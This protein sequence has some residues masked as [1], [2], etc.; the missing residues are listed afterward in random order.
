MKKTDPLRHSQRGSAL[1][2]VMMLSMGLM[3]VVATT[4]S[5]SLSESRMNYREAMRIEARNAA[6]AISEFGL[7][8]IRYKMD[9]RSDFTP[10][11][12]TTGTD[13]N[14]ISLPSTTY[15]GGSNVVASTSTGTS[16]EL[17]IGLM[18]PVTQ[19][20]ATG[21]YYYDEKDIANENDVLKGRYVFRFD[22]K[23]ISKATVNAP[24]RI[25][26]PAH[27]AYI[28]QTLSARASPLFSHAIFYNM[29]L[30]LWPGPTM[31]ILGGV[32]T[33]GDLWVKKQSSNGRTLNFVGPVSVAGNLYAGVK[34]V[35]TNSD[36]TTDN[37]SGYTDQ[38]NFR[39]GAGG[40]VGLYG[41]ATGTTTPNFWRDHKFGQASPSVSTIS[42]FRTWASGATNGNLQTSA[43]GVS[44][45]KTPGINTVAEARKMIESPDP[46]GA[47]ET[48][49]QK[50]STRAGLFI[51]VNPSSTTRTGYLPTG[52]LISVGQKSY[53]AFMLNGGEVLLPGQAYWGDLST[54][55][56]TAANKTLP[57]GI[58]PLITL[59]ENAM[60]D[61]RRHKDTFSL[62][63]K[64]STTN[65]YVPKSVNMIDVDMR[66]L[67]MAVEYTI[68]ARTTT[69]VYRTVV[70]ND[71]TATNHV[72]WTTFLYNPNAV[73]ESV[74]IGS[75]VALHGYTPSQW[76][77]AI[78]IHS[79]DAESRKDSGVRL[80]NGRGQVASKS[81]GSGLTIAT[82]D[83]LYILG[84]Y[85]ADGS[86]D[87]ATSGTSNSGRYP[88]PNETPCSVVSD[89]LTILSMPLYTNASSVIRQS[90]GW[91]DAFGGLRNSSS[92]YSTSWDTSPPSSSN[93]REGADDE[94]TWRRV[95]YD[96]TSTEMTSV[97]TTI[98]YYGNDTEISSAFLAGIVSSNK[99]GN[100][101][102]SGGANN[103]PRFLE[104][105]SYTS[106][107]S[108]IQSKVAIRGSIVAMFESAVAI[109]PWNW[110]TFD[111]PDR[112]WGFNELFNSGR[113][114]PLTPRMMYYRRV[115]FSD[116]TEAQYKALKTGWGL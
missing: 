84:H 59:R 33:N 69:S 106:G 94:I 102:N 42:K 116:I 58:S 41:P 68:N 24:S 39:T 53:R 99:D 26:G 95:P 14:S 70:P 48:E 80:I 44:V 6:E 79:M 57:A 62:A 52:A 90:R 25:A 101:Q 81:D 13:A 54:V 78:Y 85:N 107:G 77:G 110:R 9:S 28:A 88:E 7:A 22:I 12:F 65:R 34:T 64:R 19:S 61:L 114:P 71:G 86:I 55:A 21:L 103:Y 49:A 76:N 93:Q 32:H 45:A 111:A 66:T 72:S 3:V 5:Y 60:E 10:T 56:S 96:R 27:T 92:Q 113:F 75:T 15:W 89:A 109:E 91:N 40:L 36:G 2:T 35:I 63:K 46:A 51:A 82:N 20:T 112:L 67:K 97:K 38:V 47:S 73:P 43:H 29:D 115:D 87:A 18:T 4:L 74:T 11:R 31:N 100:G 108:S 1:A 37:L 8:Q 105:F 98:K 50:Y 83:A 30:E 104:D 17:I 23:V 16:P